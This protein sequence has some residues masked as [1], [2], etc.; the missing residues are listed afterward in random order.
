MTHDI[1]TTHVTGGGELNLLSKFQLPT[2]YGLRVKV[3]TFWLAQTLLWQSIIAAKSYPVQVVGFTSDPW[4]AD[5]Q[6]DMITEATLKEI[7][8]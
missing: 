5:N 1:D 2:S 8:S 4:L 3:L 6:E 7:Y